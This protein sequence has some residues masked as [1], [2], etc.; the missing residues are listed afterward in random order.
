M[1]T[2]WF[3]IIWLLY[4]LGQLVIMIRVMTTMSPQKPT[5]LWGC[6]G[7]AV[8]CASSGVT[9][10]RGSS[11][12]LHRARCSLCPADQGL[13][14]P[15]YFFWGWNKWWMF[16]IISN[17]ER[18]GW[19]LWVMGSVFQSWETMTSEQQLANCPLSL[20]G[21]TH[22]GPGHLAQGWTHDKAGPYKSQAF[23]WVVFDHH[24]KDDDEIDLIA[25]PLTRPSMTRRMVTGQSCLAAWRFWVQAPNRRYFW[26]TKAAQGCSSMCEPLPASDQYLSCRCIAFSMFG[27]VWSSYMKTE[28]QQVPTQNIPKHPMFLYN[29]PVFNHLSLPLDQSEALQTIMAS[30]FAADFGAR[31]VITEEGGKDFIQWPWESWRDWTWWLLIHK[32]RKNHPQLIFFSPKLI[33]LVRFW[34]YENEKNIL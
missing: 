7:V 21:A 14:I 33:S 29:H 23:F 9:S 25:E 1:N 31:F 13:R 2:W 5:T 20:T 15:F 12:V 6:F 3:L 32:R 27:P 8:W 30:W 34:K 10:H 4:P 11:P 22:S 16:R 19:S 26:G 17:L 28:Y 18:Y 24:K